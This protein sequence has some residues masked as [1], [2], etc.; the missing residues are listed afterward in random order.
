MYQLAT[1]TTYATGES[2]ILSDDMMLVMR[3]DEAQTRINR[4]VTYWCENL[5]A[6]FFGF[7]THSQVKKCI[8]S[9]G[10]LTQDDIFQLNSSASGR[11]KD[12]NVKYK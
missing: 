7:L 3:T 8:E 9:D 1:K 6:S 2:F 12:L 4:E 11:N 10:T 5:K